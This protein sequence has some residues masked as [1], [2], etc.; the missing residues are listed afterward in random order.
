MVDYDHMELHLFNSLTRKKE[1]FVPQDESQ[2]KL[3]T[4]GPTVYNYLH[5][6]NLRTYVFEDVL[7]RVLLAN[8]YAVNHVINITDVGHLTDDGDDG[9]DKLEKAA[10]K[11]KKDV[12]ELAKQYTD[13][14]QADF[15][16]LNILPPEKYTVATQYIE[17]QI[18]LVKQLEA[19]GITY[20]TS[21]GVYF[22][23]SMFANYGKLMGE[24]HLKGIRE[25]A[26]I[27]KNSEKRNATDFALW[28]FSPK[29]TTRQMEWDSPW[30][31]GFPGW[32]VECSA[33][34]MAELG[35][36]LDIHC[37]G[38]DHIPVHHS[39]EIA[40]SETATGKPFAKFWCHGEFLVI[41][42]ARMGK[43]MG[44]F[45]TLSDVIERGLSPL[46]YRYFLLQTHYRKQLNFTWEALGAAQTAF[47]K[48]VSRLT[49]HSTAEYDSE[50]PLYN[51]VLD[52]LND[53]LNAPKALATIWKVVKKSGN[54]DE[55]TAGAV[56]AA[57]ELLGL[58]LREV[59]QEV[60]S[61]TL[62]IP[63]EVF[64]ILDERKS[65]RDAKDWEKSDI[66]RDSIEKLGWVV[67]DTPDGQQNVQKKK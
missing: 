58:P 46:A 9:E 24:A 55:Q 65:A 66:L 59:V 35:E 1:P 54:L 14:F 41:D 34:A 7:K 26:R 2:V 4:C 13:A 43:S 6:G 61:Q 40:Q 62:P 53:D 67:T 5:I 19:K 50:S 8:D 20:Q 60:D 42:N 64:A 51:D 45:I 52:A 12:W 27:E 31:T 49:V 47:E 11:D 21:D 18:D 48:L 28:K 32:H 39:N 3:Y 36:T 29:D 15:K 17:Q 23:T 25:G 33:M 16:K 37:G 10:A 57:G 30:G 56:F 38:I 63:E 44:N 22:D